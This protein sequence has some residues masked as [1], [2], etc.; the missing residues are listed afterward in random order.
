MAGIS[1][2]AGQRRPDLVDDRQLG[3]ALAGL[4][5]RPDPAQGGRDVLA[6]EGEQVHVG[7]GVVLPFVVGLDGEHADR[8]SLRD[9]WDAEPVRGR[10]AQWIDLAERDQLL[11]AGGR[12]HGSVGPSAGR[13]PSFPAPAPSRSAP[14]CSGPGD[15]RRTGPRSTGSSSPAVLRRT[16]RCRSCRRTSARRRSRGS[17]G[18]TPPCPGPRSPCRRSGRARPGPSA[19]APAR[20]RRPR[21]RRPAPGGRPA[22]RA[23][24][25]AVSEPRCR[26]RG[27]PSVIELPRRSTRRRREVGTHRWPHGIL[28]RVVGIGTPGGLRW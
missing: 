5:D 16:A 11:P 2:C 14:R 12:E 15:R 3:V 13:R 24:G 4:L 9:E 17:P 20:P 23:G 21:A 18:R 22:R 27:R 26:R 7:V 1:T 25:V 8:P 28:V 10:H 6:D 19:P